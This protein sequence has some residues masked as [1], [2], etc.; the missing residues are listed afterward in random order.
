MIHIPMYNMH[1]IICVKISNNTHHI[2]K[3]TKV[4]TQSVHNSDMFQWCF[5]LQGDFPDHDGGHHWNIMWTDSELKNHECMFPT[6]EIFSD[7]NIAFLHFM[8]C[9]MKYSFFQCGSCILMY[10]TQLEKVVHFETG[11][12][13]KNHDSLQIN[14]NRS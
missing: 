3:D 5:S 12:W 1:F 2:L 13:C 10:L 14:R 8:F 9:T 7:K 4:L 6:V 11:W